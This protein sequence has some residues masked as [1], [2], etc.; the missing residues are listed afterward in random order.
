MLAGELFGFVRAW[1]C[2]ILYW[3]TLQNCLNQLKK[4]SW[5]SPKVKQTP[6]IIIL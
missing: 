3:A 4:I 5:N 2:K 1:E 6:N